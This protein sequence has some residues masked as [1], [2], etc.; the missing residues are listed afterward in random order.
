MIS[1]NK[2]KLLRSLKFKKYREQHQSTLLEG[3]R[4]IDESINFNVDIK[5]IW[6]TNESMNSHQNFV[7]KLK[8]KNIDFDIIDNKDF[9]LISDTNHSQGV[10]AEIN[11]SKYFN[12]KI[13]DV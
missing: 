4:L 2:I 9:K 6:M 7:D 5:S 10:I 8:T 1:K 11:I 3:L 13:S 12:Q